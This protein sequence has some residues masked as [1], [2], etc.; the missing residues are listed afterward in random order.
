[1]QSCGFAAL[2]QLSSIAKISFIVGSYT[3][4]FSAASI[5]APLAGLFGGV[6]G[7]SVVFI[8]RV[9]LHYI[10]F[11]T[12]SLKFLAFCIP[13]FCASLYF[14]SRSSI[15]RVIVPLVCMVLFIVHPVGN[16]AFFYSFYWFIPIVLFFMKRETLFMQALGSTFVAH[17]VGSVI[18]LY[19]VPMTATMWM[20]LIPIVALERFVFAM[21]MVVVCK[22]AVLF[23]KSIFGK[24]LRLRSVQTSA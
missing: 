5:M 2:V 3:A 10:I 7:A 24:L 16:Q 4:W 9:A 20:A 12:I 13:G 15:I 14:A 1:M 8:F 6:F 11:K 17:A 23:K 18:W 19:T 21:G 22:S